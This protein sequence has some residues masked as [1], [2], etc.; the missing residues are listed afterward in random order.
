MNMRKSFT[1]TEIANMLGLDKTTIGKWIDAGKLK[2]F[3]TSGGHRRVFPEELSVYFK[4]MNM[5]VPEEV[6]VKITKW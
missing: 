4:S 2:G 6:K 1:T 3:K 5:E